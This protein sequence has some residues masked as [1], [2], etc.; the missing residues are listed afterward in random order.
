VADT[1][2]F[3]EHF[4]RVVGMGYLTAAFAAAPC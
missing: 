1:G 3:N 2:A 4:V